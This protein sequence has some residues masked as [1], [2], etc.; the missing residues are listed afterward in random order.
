MEIRELNNKKKY[1]SSLKSIN[2]YQ[3]EIIKK[4]CSY[5]DDYNYRAHK[6]NHFF[7]IKVII[8]L[9]RYFSWLSVCLVRVYLQIY[10]LMNNSFEI[11]MQMNILV[12]F[13]FGNVRRNNKFV[14]IE[15][16]ARHGVCFGFKDWFEC[17]FYTKLK[18]PITQCFVGWQ[19]IALK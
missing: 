11:K 6:K 13:F 5:Q 9:V 7:V 8:F 10:I 12:F 3:V 1:Y 19:I 16:L 4:K 14:I 17:N 15:Q 2:K 18:H